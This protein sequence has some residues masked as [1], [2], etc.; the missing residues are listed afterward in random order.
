VWETRADGERF[1]TEKL[2]PAIEEPAAAA[3][4]RGDDSVPAEHQSWYELHDSI[5]GQRLNGGSVAGRA[6]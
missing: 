1:I 6:P 2:E 5:A 3:A 4:E